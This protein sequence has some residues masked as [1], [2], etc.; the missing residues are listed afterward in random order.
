MRRPWRPR[1]CLSCGEPLEQWSAPL[2]PGVYVPCVVC[3][4]L[5]VVDELDGVLISVVLAH[6]PD[7]VQTIFRDLLAAFWASPSPTPATP[8]QQQRR[9]A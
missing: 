5:Y 3:A 2:Q 4:R 9:A 8:A 1:C 7:F 6:E